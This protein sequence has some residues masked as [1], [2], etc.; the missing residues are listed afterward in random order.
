MV[1][2][3]CEDTNTQLSHGSHGCAKLSWEKTAGDRDEREDCSPAER[4]SCAID[5]LTVCIRNGREYRR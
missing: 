3:A 5:A 1:L 2:M 4:N